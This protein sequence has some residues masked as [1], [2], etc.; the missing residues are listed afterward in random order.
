[1][2]SA[3]ATSSPG[4]KPARSIAVTSVSIAS[5][6]VEKAGHQPPSSATPCAHRV[7]AATRRRID[8]PRR[9]IRAL[10][11]RSRARG[12]TIMKSWMSTRRPAC[13]PPPKIWICGIGSSVAPSPPSRRRATHRATPQPRAQPP[14]T[15]RASRWHRDGTWSACRRA[16]SGGVERG[17]IVGRA[18]DQRVGDLSVDMADRAQHIEPAEDGVA[19]RNSIASRVPCDAPAGVIVRPWN[20]RPASLRPRPSVVHG[21]PRRAVRG[22]NGSSWIHRSI[23]SRHSAATGWSART[24]SFRS[25]RPRVAPARAAL[26]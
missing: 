9:S 24:G 8:R 13:A 1:M 10:P 7:T 21:C 15:P 12:Q 20:H 5:S 18:A 14:S 16:R 19:S 25:A 26:R 23:S 17:L 4:T 22:S 11:Q 3:M 2:S 6:F